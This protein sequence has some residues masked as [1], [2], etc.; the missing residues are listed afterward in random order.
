M[1]QKMNEASCFTEIF[2]TTAT[3]IFLPSL[4]A[5]AHIRLQKWAQ[6][7]LSLLGSLFSAG[8]MFLSPAHTPSAGSPSRLQAA[9]SP[10]AGGPCF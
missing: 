8:R 4:N 3:N 9:P 5:A 1:K 6:S 7:T 2:F 10:A